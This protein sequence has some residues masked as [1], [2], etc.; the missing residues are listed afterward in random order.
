MIVRTT[1]VPKT[2]AQPASTASL[3][4]TAYMVATFIKNA[5]ALPTYIPVLTGQDSRSP[6]ESGVVFYADCVVSVG[7][8]VDIGAVSW[9]GNESTI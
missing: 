2:A 1:T 7:P 5:I 6:H 9:P 4:F 3:R 8:G